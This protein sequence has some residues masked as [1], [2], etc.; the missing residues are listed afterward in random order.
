MKKG[1]LLYGES[2]ILYNLFNI[3]ALERNSKK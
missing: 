3:K 1:E 2:H